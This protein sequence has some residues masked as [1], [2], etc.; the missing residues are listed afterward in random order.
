MYS[1]KSVTFIEYS[2]LLLALCSQKASLKDK[3]FTSPSKAP[4]IKGKASSPGAEDGTEAS[5]SKGT[6]SWS[7][8]RGG[9]SRQNSDGKKT[10]CSKTE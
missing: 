5:P 8:V 7:R 1:N 9:A 6:K 3:M 2:F 4:V 10:K